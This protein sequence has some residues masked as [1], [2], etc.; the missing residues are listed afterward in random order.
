MSETAQLIEVLQRQH[1]EQMQILQDQNKQL[2]AALTSKPTPANATNIPSF[3]SFDSTGELWTDYWDRFQTFVK[4]HSIPSDK[5]AQVFLTNQ[6]KVTYKLLSN[7]ASQLTPAIEVNLLT[8]DQISEYMKEQFDPTRYIVRE[9]YKFWSD[10][11]RKPGESVQELAAR[12]R[13][14]AVTCNFTSIKDPQDEALRTRFICSVKNEAVLKALFRIKDEELTFAKAVAVANETED[15]AK[16]AKDTVYG[17]GKAQ[18][19][20]NEY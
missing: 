13:Q 18:F 10:L 16:V 19:V 17:E 4:V 20:I 6:T 5:V 2:L 1:R 7:Y 15:A 12:I 3:A 14:D 9:R 11:Q 8:I